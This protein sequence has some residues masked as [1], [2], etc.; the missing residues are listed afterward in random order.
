MAE[1]PT[2]PTL[3]VCKV[4]TSVRVHMQ[5]INWLMMIMMLILELGIKKKYDV[6]I[7][8]ARSLSLTL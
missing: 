4:C 1:S 6:K 2:T 8:V 7:P 5:L 3:L